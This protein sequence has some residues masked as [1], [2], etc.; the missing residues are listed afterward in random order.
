LLKFLRFCFAFFTAILVLMGSVVLLARAA[1]NPF[2]SLG[3]D[4][5]EGQPCFMGVT[6]NVTPWNDAK[7]ALAQYDEEQ[8][9]K[10]LRIPVNGTMAW[11]ESFDGNLVTR[12]SIYAKRGVPFSDVGSFINLYGAP[13]GVQV[14]RDERSLILV[15]PSALLAVPL[16]KDRL[17]KQ[18]PIAFIDMEN[19]AASYKFGACQ[20]AEEYGYYVTPWLGFASVDRYR[21][22]GLFAVY[23]N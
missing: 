10:M 1:T 2:Q 7:R 21:S 3:F 6:P 4:Q 23:G 15:Y 17:T 8:M 22:Q 19:R 13:C 16:G 14:L 20:N 5:C 12:I 18:V 11:I 9:G